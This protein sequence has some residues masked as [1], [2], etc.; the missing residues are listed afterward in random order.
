MADSRFPEPKRPASPKRED[1]RRDPNLTPHRQSDDRSI[2]RESYPGAKRPGWGTDKDYDRR[3]GS[4]TA[5]YLAFGTTGPLTSGR[6]VQDQ[7]NR[8]FESGMRKVGKVRDAAARKIAA[9][10]DRHIGRRHK[11]KGSRSAGGSR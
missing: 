5:G 9:A 7:V 10:E 11:L 8:R 1:A 2:Q 6:D 4:P 3:P